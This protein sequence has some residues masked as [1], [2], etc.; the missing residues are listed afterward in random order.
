MAARGP[1][2]GL[3]AGERAPPLSNA[4]IV[5]R[6]SALVN[7]AER[8]AALRAAHGRYLDRLLHAP[9][10]SAPHKPPRVFDTRRRGPVRTGTFCGAR[11]VPTP[12]HHPPL[13]E[14]CAP[15]Y[16]YRMSC[17][18]CG[19]AGVVFQDHCHQSGK[20]RGRLCNSCNVSLS[21]Y[22]DNPEMLRIKAE[23]LRFESERILA[24]A[25]G[26]SLYSRIKRAAVELSLVRAEVLEGLAKY[27][28][29]RS[30]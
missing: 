10:V 20:F 22:D 15:C 16:T 5:P 21:V 23:G 9:V 25:Q 29:T 12:E 17:E 18:V 3:G 19:F 30:K 11:I 4:R 13:D 27:L 1:G 2:L 24:I 26:D 28:E 6:A 8:M 7:C 14:R